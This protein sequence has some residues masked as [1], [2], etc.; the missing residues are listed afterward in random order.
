L[1]RV[2]QDNAAINSIAF[3]EKKPLPSDFTGHTPLI[4]I[5]FHEDMNGQVLSNSVF[6]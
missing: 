2:F 4:K 5:I 3:N 6:G 1:H